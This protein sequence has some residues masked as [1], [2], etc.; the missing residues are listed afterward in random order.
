MEFIVRGVC[1]NGSLE[2]ELEMKVMCY[3]LQW[4]R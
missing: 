2:D 4:Q 1:L 3:C